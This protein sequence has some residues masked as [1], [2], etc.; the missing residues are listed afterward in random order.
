MTPFKFRL[1]FSKSVIQLLFGNKTIPCL[2]NA[3]LYIEHLKH[4]SS[5]RYATKLGLYCREDSLERWEE[6]FSRPPHPHPTRP[7]VPTGCLLHL[8]HIIRTV[9]AAKGDDRGGDR[10]DV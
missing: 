1:Y 7:L 6:A 3:R 5:K 10:G 8:A 4:M 2:D 9:A